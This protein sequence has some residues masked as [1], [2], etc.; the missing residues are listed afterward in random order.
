MKHLQEMLLKGAEETLHKCRVI[1]M[2]GILPL[3]PLEEIPV[4]QSGS[5]LRQQPMEFLGRSSCMQRSDA[6]ANLPGGSNCH[7]H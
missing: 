5:V 2:E 4:Q 7:S 1:E 6:A 3:M